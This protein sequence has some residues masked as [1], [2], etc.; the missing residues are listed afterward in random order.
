[1]GIRARSSVQFHFLCFQIL[2]KWSLHV[3]TN[4]R[5]LTIIIHTDSM[6]YI[7]RYIVD[8]LLTSEF[9]PY[10]IYSQ[11]YMVFTEGQYN[12]HFLEEKNKH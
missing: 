7:H 11:L 3:R 10:Q 8:V 12:K 9:L 5:H 6:I 1:M 2:T 4:I